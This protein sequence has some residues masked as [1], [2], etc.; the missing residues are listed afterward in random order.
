[1]IIFAIIGVCVAFYEAKSVFTIYKI[2][3]DGDLNNLLQIKE[4][5]ILFIL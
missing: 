2:Y 5:F 4:I 1:M 3:H